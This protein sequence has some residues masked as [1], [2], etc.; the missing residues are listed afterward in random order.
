LK[1]VA[2]IIESKVEILK[3][4]RRREDS[5]LP[6]K[7]PTNAPSHAISKWFPAVL[8]KFAEGFIQHALRFELFSVLPIDGWISVNLGK[9]RYNGLVLLDLIFSAC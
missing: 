3:Q 5:F 2:G 9:Q 1:L 8:G 7:G 4:H 6:G